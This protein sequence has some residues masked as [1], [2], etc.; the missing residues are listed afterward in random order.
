[1][2]INRFYFKVRDGGVR[3]EVVVRFFLKV[4]SYGRKEE[5]VFEIV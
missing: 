5:I 3:I 1:M 2:R 4:V